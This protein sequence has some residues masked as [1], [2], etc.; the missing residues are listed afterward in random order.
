MAA[1]RELAPGAVSHSS[2]EELLRQSDAEWVGIGSPNS[3][4]A[5]Q[6]AAALDEGRH[7]FCEKP[8]ATTLDDCAMIRDA[9]AALADA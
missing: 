7:V 8:L 5:W 6:V 9:V 4:H 1:A 3:E 2:V